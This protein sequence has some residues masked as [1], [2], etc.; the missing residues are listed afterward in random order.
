MLGG[1]HHVYTHV[2]FDTGNGIPPPPINND[3]IITITATIRS[4]HNWGEPERA[5]H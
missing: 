4:I 2:G 1:R 5:P 3:I